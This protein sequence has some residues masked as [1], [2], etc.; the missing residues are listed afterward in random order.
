MAVHR[1]GVH[2]S[3]AHVCE[4]RRTY[5]VDNKIAVTRDKHGGVDHKRLGLV[6]GHGYAL[7]GCVALSNGER[8]VRLRNPWEEYEWTGD[9]CDSDPRWSSQFLDEVAASDTAGGPIRNANDSVF[10]MPLAA[11]RKYFS[12]GDVCCC[13]IKPREPLDPPLTDFV[14]PPPPFMPPPQPKVTPAADIGP[15]LGLRATA[16]RVVVPRSKLDFWGL[17]VRHLRFYKDTN[18]EEPITM[19]DGWLPIDSGSASDNGGDDWIP[20]N[21]LFDFPG[22]KT[23]WGGRAAPCENGS[24]AERDGEPHDGELSAWWLGL[25]RPDWVPGVAVL[26]ISFECRDHYPQCEIVCEGLVDDVWYKFGG[27]DGRNPG[28]LKACWG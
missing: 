20:A 25:R 26:G 27:V 14:D 16:W 1:A 28:M 15:E 12:G 9:W 5:L 23:W 21:A 17:D 18:L 3:L 2:Q 11:F 4:L 8:L 13:E 24:P 19:E 22:K 10:F 6:P 7:V